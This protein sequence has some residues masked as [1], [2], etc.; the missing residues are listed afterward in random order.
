MDYSD[1]DLAEDLQLKDNELYLD[2]KNTI[3]GYEGVNEDLAKASAT[4]FVTQYGLDGVLAHDIA[5]MYNVNRD[6]MI[7]YAQIYAVEEKDVT[8]QGTTAERYIR[9]YIASDQ[10]K[11]IN[12]DELATTEDVVDSCAK[13]IKYAME[14]DVNLDEYKA[15][16]I[17]VGVIWTAVAVVYEPEPTARITEILQYEKFSRT[18]VEE[19]VEFLHELGKEAVRPNRE[20]YDDRKI[21][22]QVSSIM[23]DNGFS[24]EE[25][26]EVW[27]RYHSL[28]RE[29]LEQYDNMATAY[30]IVEEADIRYMDIN[31]VNEATVE[32]IKGKLF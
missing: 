27:K 11:E 24:H 23:L 8:V 29:E 19:V 30:A 14:S 28:E 6:D 13:T 32:R 1:V 3:E 5:K 17:A 15:E 20:L 26:L 10:L 22:V 31:S 7:D 9:D 12:V 21:A 16:T 25:E 4:Y 2:A 18:T